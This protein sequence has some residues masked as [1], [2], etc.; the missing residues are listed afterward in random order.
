MVTGF[1]QPFAKVQLCVLPSLLVIAQALEV[2]LA[3]YHAR[4]MRYDL[5]LLRIVPLLLCLLCQTR[6]NMV[7]R[8]ADACCAD[9]SESNVG[10]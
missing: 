3:L 1:Q 7:N 9:Q 4:V 2:K 5:H 6:G 8:A 10:P